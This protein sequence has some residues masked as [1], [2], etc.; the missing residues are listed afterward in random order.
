MDIANQDFL[1]GN[2][3]LFG[4]S[5]AG[6]TNLGVISSSGGNV[7]LAGYTVNNEGSISASR[8]RNTAF[9]VY[10]ITG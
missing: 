1:N 9:I 10:G 5:N 8:S 4:T 6:V 3:N 2:L 7:L